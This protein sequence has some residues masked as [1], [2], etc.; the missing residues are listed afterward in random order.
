MKTA[1]RK[2]ETGKGLRGKV[3]RD[4][5]GDVKLKMARINKEHDKVR[6]IVNTSVWAKIQVLN[7]K[8][9]S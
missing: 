1:N 2:V 4:L 3:R 7:S 8:K 9:S 5:A 6:S